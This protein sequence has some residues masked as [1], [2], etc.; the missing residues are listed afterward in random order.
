MEHQDH[1]GDELLQQR[2]SQEELVDTIQTLEDACL[3]SQY[4]DRLGKMLAL[5]DDPHLQRFIRDRSL[6]KLFQRIAEAYN[7]NDADRLLELLYRKF[8]VDFVFFKDLMRHE[9]IEI[10]FI[11]HNEA[12]KI[13]AK[14]S[15]AIT[16][17]QYTSTRDGQFN[18][19]GALMI[20]GMLGIMLKIAEIKQWGMEEFANAFAGELDWLLPITL[21]SIEVSKDDGLIEDPS[22]ITED[23]RGRI[24]QLD[25]EA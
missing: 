11:D 20:L 17:G 18:I 14:L 19:I 2:L 4:F 23:L 22:M 25:S 1:I 12:D 24:R 13:F 5:I 3:S 21:T 16:L 8:T 15:D 6:L 10:K 9:E 7:M